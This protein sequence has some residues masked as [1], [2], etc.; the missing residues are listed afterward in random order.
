[1]LNAVWLTAPPSTPPIEPLILSLVERTLP[2]PG[3]RQAFLDELARPAK[4]TDVILEHMGLRETGAEPDG[5]PPLI[6]VTAKSAEHDPWRDTLLLPGGACPIA[7]LVETWDRGRVALVHDSFRHL[8]A[9]PQAFIRRQAAL[10][11]GGASAEAIAAALAEERGGAF[12]YAELVSEARRRI[13][14]VLDPSVLLGP[15]GSI[16]VQVGS[17]SETTR[18]LLQEGL[19]GE[20]LFILPHLLFEGRTNYA[21]IE[22]LIY[23]NF[24]AGQGQATRLVGTA[25]QRQTLERLLTLVI[26]GVFDPAARDAATFESLHARYAIGDPATLAFLRATH[27]H[28]A[29][30]DSAD[31]TGAI[32][33]L[34]SYLDV[35]ELSADGTDIP[36]RRTN[37]DGSQTLVGTVWVQR[38]DDAFDVRVTQADGAVVAKRLDVTTRRRLLRPVPPPAVERIRFGTERPRFGVTPLGTSHGFDPAGDVTTFVVWI[39]GRGIVVDPSPEALAYLRGMGVADADLPFVFLTHVHAD[40]DGGLIELILTGGR[41]TLIASDVVFRT[42]VEKARLLTG[43]DVEREGLVTHVRANPGRPTVIEVGGER[44]RIDTRWNLHP[45]PTNGFRITV[46]DRTFGYAGDTQYDPALIGR[47]HEAGAVSDAQQKDLL[48]FFWRPDGTP[49]VDLLYH[50]AGIPPIHTERAVL[51]R[52]PDRIRERMFLVHIADQDVPPGAVPSKPELFHTTVFLGAD[53]GVRRDVLLSTMRLVSYLYDAPVN[54]LEKLL[55]RGVLRQYEAGAV[56]VHK[57]PRTSDSPLTFYVVVDGEIAVRDGRRLTTTL[58]KGDSFGEWGI[59]HQRGFRTADVVATRASQCLEFGEEEYRWLVTQCPAIQERIGIIRRLMP[60]LQNA[61]AR[62]R[63]KVE[64]DPGLRPSVVTGMNAGQLASFAL[65]GTLKTFKD[66]EP[67]IIEGE[68]ADGFYVLL[69]GHLLATVG[70]L[71]IGEVAEGEMFGEVAALDGRRRTATIATVS[72][73]AEVLFMPMTAFQHLLHTVP[74]FALEVRNIA[75]RR[76]ARR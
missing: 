4:R 43:H 76:A 57:G 26:F 24:F 19:R 71:V 42:F 65:F 28:Y 49:T 10:A 67:I 11:E 69:S 64:A 7:I 44:A 46:G 36:I 9:G 73:E 47:L 23:L 55:D 13:T 38:A 39:N 21:D 6:F 70:G 51:A 32:K 35:T 20:H 29:V 48:H 15:D 14:S 3:L 66:G 22:F 17:V 52:L 75:S 45:I 72:A 33:P 63:L 54:V 31:G 34:S 68:E 58:Q 25:R 74:S 18:N 62:D 56:I 30:R 27:Q 12:R 5:R 61:Q 40:H 8:E 2:R 37:T 59:S 53:E 60:Q 50:E 41:T 16:R 1:M